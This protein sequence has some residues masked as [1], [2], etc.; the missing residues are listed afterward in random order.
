MLARVLVVLAAA[1]VI[2]CGGKNPRAYPNDSPWEAP[3]LDTPSQYEAAAET[4]QSL[5]DLENLR[6][7]ASDPDHPSFD[8]IVDQ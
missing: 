6:T 5:D 2:G 8:S 1:L 7:P 4:E 3:T